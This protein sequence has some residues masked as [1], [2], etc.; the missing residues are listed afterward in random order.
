[1]RVLTVVLLCAACSS[2]P[3]YTGTYEGDFFI[4]LDPTPL[5]GNPNGHGTI[6]AT[7][8]GGKVTGTFDVAITSGSQVS[9]STGTVSGTIGANN[10]IDD[11]TLVVD[12]FSPNCTPPQ[13]TANGQ[14]S[15]ADDSGTTRLMWT[16]SGTST[17]GGMTTQVDLACTPGMKRSTP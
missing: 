4:L 13:F 14:A 15:L 9:M 3:S 1:M 2:D 6:T 17:C 12:M 8:A 11:W 7:E 16:A 5:T 10:A